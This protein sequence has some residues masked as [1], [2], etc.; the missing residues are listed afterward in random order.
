M[1]KKTRKKKI[2]TVYA[3]P[4]MKYNV[5]LHKFE[6]DLPAVKKLHSENKADSFKLVIAFIVIAMGLVAVVY[7]MS[8]VR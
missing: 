4:P 2:R 5:A 8:R 3:E 6:P 1:K 7:L